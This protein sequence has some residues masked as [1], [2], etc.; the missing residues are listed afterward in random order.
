MI[1]WKEIKWENKII[2]SN[3]DIDLDIFF[4]QLFSEKSSPIVLYTH[5]E[6]YRKLKEKYCV[7]PKNN[8]NSN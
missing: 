8:S 6:C 2:E 1:N 5:P 3:D 7:N 4:Y